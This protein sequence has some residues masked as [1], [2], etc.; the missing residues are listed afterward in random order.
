MAARQR[1]PEPVE[2]GATYVPRERGNG[3]LVRLS[4]SRPRQAGNSRSAKGV[5]TATDDHWPWPRP[6]NET[7]EPAT[8]PPATAQPLAIGRMARVIKASL[9]AGRL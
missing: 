3:P 2:A 5:I 9:R 4:Q 1:S 8:T 7:A 6:P